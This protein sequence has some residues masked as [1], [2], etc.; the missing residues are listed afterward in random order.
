MPNL[1]LRTAL[2]ATALITSCLAQPSLVLSS[3]GTVPGGTAALSLSLNG[4]AGSLPAALQWSFAPSAGITALTVAASPSLT[5]AG[6]SIQ[7]AGTGM[8]TTCILYGVDSAEVPSG[9]LAVVS[10]TLAANA[11]ASTVGLANVLGASAT[12]NPVAIPA[13]G[14]AVAVTQYLVSGLSCTAGSLVSGATTA[15]TVTLNAPA[16]SGATVQLASDAASLS[17]PASVPVAAGAWG[18]PFM[19]SAG[20]INADQYAT[21]TATL[22][23]ASANTGVALT[24][25]PLNL[26][27]LQCTPATLMPNAPATCTATLTRAAPAGGTTISLRSSTLD[28]AVPL[29]VVVPANATTAA[30]TAAAGP[31]TAAQTAVVTATLASVS[32][33]ATI[34]MVLP[35]TLSTL[36][37]TPMKIF[38]GAVGTCTVSLTSAASSTSLVVLAST[39]PGLIVPAT[40]T[41]LSGGTA[42]NFAF[43]TSTSL[44]GWA[45]LSAS[46]GSVKR[47]FAF[48]VSAATGSLTGAV[49]PPPASV[50]L[51][52]EGT[53]DWAHWGLTTAAD[54]NHKAAAASQIGTFSTIGTMA[55]TRYT[56]C[57]VLFTWTD[58]TPVSTATNAKTGV[59]VTGLGNGFRLTVPAGVAPMT[60]R[61]YVGGWNFQ[62]SLVAHLSD[63]SAPDYVDT[64]LAAP[65]AH[66]KQGVYS[67]MFHA[68]SA[69]QTLTVTYTM[70]GTAGGLSLH[71]AT[72]Q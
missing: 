7:C 27:A 21:I 28:L 53:L 72:L 49:A 64:S 15:C 11:A 38:P 18:A 22:N 46:L 71:A 33:T 61:I 70:Q 66:G 42:A 14:G 37:C 19:A 2:V 1:L 48:T 68:A 58:G 25:P 40:V 32:R 6:K 62:G 13:T 52:N 20:T 60:L 57:P 36:T 47:S 39:N 26:A 51:T 45:I 30:F 16:V 56:D 69:G 35:A 9:P 34:S 43:S 63:G 4:S 44:G 8:A 41:V 3:A 65:P 5:A 55:A 17:V 54:F 12:G 59:Y 67:L 29:S 23:G 24:A 10:V 50:Q 31:F